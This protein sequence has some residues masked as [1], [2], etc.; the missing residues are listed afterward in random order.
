MDLRQVQVYRLAS[1]DSGD[2]F[3]V[4]DWKSKLSR[5]QAV[6]ATLGGTSI[7]EGLNVCDSSYGDGARVI[8]LP[9]RIKTDI[10]ENGWANI[11]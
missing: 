11:Y 1:M 6:D 10:D 4:G 9:A 3:V 2:R 5:Q 7:D 8:G